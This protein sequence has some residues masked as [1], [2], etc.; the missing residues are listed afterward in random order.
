M[1]DLIDDGHT[2]TRSTS[3]NNS[4]ALP[5]A[6]ALDSDSD[7]DDDQPPVWHGRAGTSSTVSMEDEARMHALIMNNDELSRKLREAEETLQR[8]LSEH[9]AELEEFTN[10]LEEARA[11][12]AAT[13]RE[14]KELRA[15]EKTN[16]TQISG[17]ESD[18]AKLTKQV[19][20]SRT[21]YQGL[22]K[23]YLEQCGT[24]P[25]HAYTLSRS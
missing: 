23:Q 12:L 17:L 24:L 19:E 15:K 6:S 14:E 16:S 13:R 1:H 9:E 5:R 7:S 21:S 11:E 3:A 2:L 20:A 18:I 10:R 25:Y 8:R 22:N 4:I